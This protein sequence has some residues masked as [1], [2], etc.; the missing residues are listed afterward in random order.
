MKPSQALKE[1]KRSTEA[2]YIQIEKEV[3]RQV[4]DLRQLNSLKKYNIPAVLFAQA[5]QSHHA[6][7]D[8]PSEKND[9]KQLVFWHT[10]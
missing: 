1:R 8:L 10:S 2:F 4:Q 3:A 7:F 6:G 5:V 9:I